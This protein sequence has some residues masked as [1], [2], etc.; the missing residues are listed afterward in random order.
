MY[1]LRSL[2]MVKGRKS[3]PTR[4]CRKN[5]GPAD[6]DRTR[7]HKKSSKGLATASSTEASTMSRALLTPSSPRRDAVISFLAVT[8][9]TA[10]VP[11][12]GAIGQVVRARRHRVHDHPPIDIGQLRHCATRHRGIAEGHS[13]RRNVARDD[14]PS[15]DERPGADAHEGQYC[16]VD[17]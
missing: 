12:L 2:S 16:Y 3:R 13:R 8:S 6:V 7:Q 10:G 9:V 14:G 4:S 5:A 15:S 11:S 1:M 17:A